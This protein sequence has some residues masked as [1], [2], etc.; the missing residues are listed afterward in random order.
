[1]EKQIADERARIGALD[2]GLDNQRTPNLKAQLRLATHILDD[3]DAALRH[4][5]TIQQQHDVAMWMGFAALNLKHATEMR[6][7]IQAAIDSRG[8]PQNI[9]EV[10]R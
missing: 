1:M 3:A 8:G 7:K 4:A 2:A 5:G 10:G 9:V 6:E